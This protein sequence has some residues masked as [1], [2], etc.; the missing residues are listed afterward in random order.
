MAAA[1]A[2]YQDCETPL[3]LSDKW[4]AKINLM[5]EH[6]VGAEKKLVAKEEELKANKVELVAKDEELEKARTKVAQLGG[7]S[8]GPVRRSHP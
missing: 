1:W 7:S 4:A 3:G 2:A 8:L 5:K 6:V